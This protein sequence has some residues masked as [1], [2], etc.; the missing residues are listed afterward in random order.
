MITPGQTFRVPG[1]FAVTVARATKAPM[2]L[3]VA[4]AA[5]LR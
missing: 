3:K 4:L 1:E 5:S 2:Q